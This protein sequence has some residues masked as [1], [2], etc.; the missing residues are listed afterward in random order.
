MATVKFS[1]R[2]PE[3]LLSPVTRVVEPA[4]VAKLKPIPNPT[5]PKPAVTPKPVLE[6]DLDLDYGGKID[7]WW[8]ESSYDLRSGLDVREDSTIPGELIDDLF[9]RAPRRR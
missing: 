7:R 6:P 2:P 5:S 1:Y 8:Y 4:P 9:K 3:G